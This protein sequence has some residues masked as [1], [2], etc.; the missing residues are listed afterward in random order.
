MK[1]INPNTVTR[2]PKRILAWETEYKPFRLEKSTMRPGNFFSEE[3]L[4]SLEN[5]GGGD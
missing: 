1:M 4:M 5:S 2:I 3:M